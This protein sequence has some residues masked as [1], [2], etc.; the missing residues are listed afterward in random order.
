MLTIAD[1]NN[2]FY[3]VEYFVYLAPL[4]VAVYYKRYAIRGFF[5]RVHCLL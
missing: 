5:K 2:A 3:S 1:L 4:L